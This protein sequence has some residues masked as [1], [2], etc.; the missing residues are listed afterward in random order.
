M[1]SRRCR[2]DIAH[3]LSRYFAIHS[4]GSGPYRDCGGAV[5]VEG[6]CASME[7][8]VRLSGNF[9]RLKWQAGVFGFWEKVDGVLTISPLLSGTSPAT[10]TLIN[11]ALNAGTLKTD[12]L[13]AFGQVDFAVT[14]TLS[15]IAGGRYSW[16]KKTVDEFN[17]GSATTLP[18]NPNVPIP[19]VGA[20]G[21]QSWS[22]F[23]PRPEAH[24]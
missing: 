3:G 9:D 19:T 24:T 16:E 8:G 14:D 7:P 22:A 10:A 11:G 15:L 12:A 20:T 13:A 18:F 17:Q 6:K 5:S 2:A 23:T 4:E 21:S 1:G